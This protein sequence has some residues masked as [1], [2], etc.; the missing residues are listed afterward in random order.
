M[1]RREPLRYSWMPRVL[2]AGITLIAVAGGILA[3]L[4]R[5]LH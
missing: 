2:T 1:R 3:V 5:L 4:D